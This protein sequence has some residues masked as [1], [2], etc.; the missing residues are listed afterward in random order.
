[1]AIGLVAALAAGSLMRS[2]LYE[3]SPLD[4]LTY[5]VVALVLAVVSLG[6]SYLPAYRAT[7]LDPI[8]TLRDE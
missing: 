1:V 2:L 4:P 6:A 8:E 3:V 7:R 5:V